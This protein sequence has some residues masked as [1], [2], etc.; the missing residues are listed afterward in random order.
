MAIRANAEF[1]E[2]IRIDDQASEELSRAQK[3]AEIYQKQMAE[4]NGEILRL[5]KE[6][7]TLL[8]SNNDLQQ[9]QISVA[10]SAQSTSMALIQNSAAIEQNSIFTDILIGGL[11]TLAVAAAGVGIFKLAN[12]F[13]IVQQ[14]TKPVIDD[15]LKLK[16]TWSDVAE[17]L[18]TK[19][20]PAFFRIGELLWSSS[21]PLGILSVLL[22]QADSQFLNFVGT[23]TAGYCWWIFW[24]H[25]FYGYSRN[26]K[27]SRGHW[28]KTVIS[29][30]RVRG[31]V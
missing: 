22:L 14:Y 27:P 23:L 8:T 30:G 5:V 6:I 25:I 2:T 26:R 7:K 12:Q 15:F 19:I 17:T 16:K 24:R 28:I 9:S 29:Y 10:S 1:V 31:K 4:L 20:N 11:K 18:T 13:Q 3:S 21:K